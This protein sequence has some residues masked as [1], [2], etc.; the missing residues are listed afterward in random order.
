MSDTQQP[1]PELVKASKQAV[2]R[3]LADQRPGESIAQY[4]HRVGSDVLSDS[5]AISIMVDF[6][7]KLEQAGLIRFDYSH[8]VSIFE[9][10]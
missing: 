10:V 4:C 2:L 7:I 6:A 1:A 9:V 8:H 5:A 3:Y